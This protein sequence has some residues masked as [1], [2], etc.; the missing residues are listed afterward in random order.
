MK[1]DIASTDKSGKLLGNCPV[2][3][4]VGVCLDIRP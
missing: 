4:V 2:L 1:F 3:A